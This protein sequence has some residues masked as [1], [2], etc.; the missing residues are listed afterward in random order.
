MRSELPVTQL[1]G[2]RLPATA[3]I[4]VLAFVLVLV[5]GVPAGVLIGVLTR[6]G[7]RPRTELGFGAVTG[8]FR[9]RTRIPARRCVGFRIC[10]DAKA[11]PVAGG[12]AGLVSATRPV[13]GRRP[14]GDHRAHVRAETLRVL[15]QEYMRTARAKRLPAR[16]LYVRHA[17]P[18]LLAATLTLSGLALSG[19]LAG[20]VLSRTSLPGPDWAPRSR[21]PCR[22][23]TIRS[24]RH[25]RSCTGAESC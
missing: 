1:I 7:R 6:E 16:L 15:D 2:Q 13:A 25:S 3:E 14:G 22:Q 4:A 19:L 21:N 24:Y 8:L 17:L 23:R 12:R 20:T 10:R 9:G 18:N 5:I 11:F